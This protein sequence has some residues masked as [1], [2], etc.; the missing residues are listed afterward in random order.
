MTA[1]VLSTCFRWSDAPIPGESLMGFVARNSAK[2]GVTKTSSA[3][4]PADIDTL[5]PESLPTVHRD[6]AAE[7]AHL[8]KT[9]PEEVLARS[10]PPVVVPGRP[11]SFVDF[12]GTPIRS[13]YREVNRRRVSPTSLAASE[14]HRAM[15]DLR[16]F[17]FCPES[18]EILIDHCP[19]CD[20]RLGWRWTLGAAW[21]ESCGEDLRQF[22]QSRIECADME[23]LDFVV[24]LVHTDPARRARARRL[25][26]DLLQPLDN[27]EL[28]EFC[29]ALACAITTE[30][31]APRAIMRRLKTL[32]DFSRMTPDALATAARIVIGW[33]EAFHKLADAM[34]EQAFARHGFW[35]KKKELGPLIYLARDLY[36]APLIKRALVREVDANMANAAVTVAFRRAEQRQTPDLMTIGDAAAEFGLDGRMIK[37]WRDDDL[38][39]A[40]FDREAKTSIVLVRR[41]EMA[42]IAT[43]RD[44]AMGRFEVM[45]RLGVDYLAPDALAATGMIEKIDRPAADIIKGDSYRRSSVEAL[46]A[47]LLACAA[48][49]A[50]NAKIHPRLS[51][52][53]KRTGVGPAPWVAIYQAIISGALR[54][55]LHP[56]HGNLAVATSV[57]VPDAANVAPIIQAATGADVSGSKRVNTHEAAAMLGTTE[58]VIAEFIGKT[59]LPT[60]G[61][62]RFKLDRKV[63]EDFRDK[64]VLAN[65]LA[66]RMG[67]RYRDVR[68]FLLEK[69]VEPVLNKNENQHLAWDRAEVERALE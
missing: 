11:T 35:G 27:G 28:F 12:F 13:A 60:N 25:V 62:E 58:V 39:W 55:N 20:G 33:P 7:V 49:P 41:A 48:P 26:P 3:L 32:A 54:V 9:T 22:P 68:A 19:A 14:H 38:V 64:Y 34:R 56:G 18:K 63:V 24:D 42:A 50:P 29:V 31:E 1:I 53:V 36:L 61:G 57:T 66:A 17:S 6:K 10:H 8:F 51:K 5:V 69:G 15:W 43:A 37:R 21:C 40:L 23:A 47:R 44:D 59:F 45:K 65:E 67:C 30:P 4:L 16:V 52:A 46:H 2:H